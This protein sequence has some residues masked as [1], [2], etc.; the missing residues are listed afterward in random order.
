MIF[1]GRHNVTTSNPPKRNKESFYSYTQAKIE[2]K[3]LVG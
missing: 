1:T 3:K 2:T